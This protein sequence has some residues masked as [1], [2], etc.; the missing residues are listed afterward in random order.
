[1]G[2]H[3]H[4][5]LHMARSPGFGSTAHDSTRSSHSLSLRLQAHALK[6][7]MNG[8]SLGHYAK[9]TLQ[10][11][12]ATSVRNCLYVMGFRIYFTP[13]QGCFSVFA[14]A[15]RS[16]S[17]SQEYL[18]L[19]RGRPGF[20]HSF[21]SHALLRILLSRCFYAYGPITRCGIPFQVFRLET[22]NLKCSPTTPRS[23]PL[24][25]AYSVVARRYWRNLCRFLFLWLLR[26]FNSPGWLPLRDNTGSLYWVTPFGHPGVVAS[27]Q[28]ALAFRSLA[29]P[30]SPLRA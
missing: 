27:V 24:G 9:G 22:S 5:N 14:H 11:G 29:R 2:F 28:L 21:T 25:L 17:V 23:K 16:L 6:L 3:P 30:S 12:L 15:T 26:C 13:R 19:E 4:F 18:G 20:M 8:K 1:M 7:A 10:T